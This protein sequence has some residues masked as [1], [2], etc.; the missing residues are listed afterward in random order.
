MY[1]ESEITNNQVSIITQG[2]FIRYQETGSSDEMELLFKN[3]LELPIPLQANKP[4]KSL[5]ISSW[6]ICL[7]DINR[8]K[9]SR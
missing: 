2:K 1:L 6:S 3:R 9:E 7:M 5:F 4:S 8:A